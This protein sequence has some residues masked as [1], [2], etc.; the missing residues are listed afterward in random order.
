[1][2]QK[3]LIACKC[4]V[5]KYNSLKEESTSDASIVS[6]AS[7]VRHFQHACSCK[8]L[9]SFIESQSNKLKSLA[10]KLDDNQT[11]VVQTNCEEPSPRFIVN[12]NI[13][14]YSSDLNVMDYSVEIDMHV[15]VSFFAPHKY[16][17]IAKKNNL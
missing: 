17:I 10:K 8:E 14:K 2:L 7:L 6:E 15:I 1:M 5:K 3:E 13:I 9:I 16:E 12:G 4:H 11:T